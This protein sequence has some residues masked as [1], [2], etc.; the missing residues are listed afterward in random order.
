M[1]SD[2]PT[3]RAETEIGAS[4]HNRYQHR[5]PLATG[6]GREKDTNQGF[7]TALTEVGKSAV[8][9]G[10]WC[11]EERQLEPTADNWH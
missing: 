1:A 3:S 10:R 2:Q 8:L 9:T 5:W 4:G 7:G 11:K 6:K